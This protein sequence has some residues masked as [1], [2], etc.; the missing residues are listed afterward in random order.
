MLSRPSDEMVP[1]QPMAAIKGLLGII[2][3]KSPAFRSDNATNREDSSGASLHCFWRISR[4]RALV[5]SVA[6]CRFGAGW[7]A[8][9]LGIAVR[10]QEACAGS[11]RAPDDT[12]FVR[13]PPVVGPA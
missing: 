5:G 3:P 6:S 13:Q 8:G 1:P 7:Q 10:M 2:P 12:M 4:R 9:D 11:P